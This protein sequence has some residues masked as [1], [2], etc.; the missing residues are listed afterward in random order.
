VPKTT[1]EEYIAYIFRVQKGARQK[2]RENL[3]AVVEENR[4]LFDSIKYGI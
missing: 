3:A 1:L 4:S 2:T